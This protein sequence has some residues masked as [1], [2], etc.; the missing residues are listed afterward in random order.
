MSGEV[1]LEVAGPVAVLRFNRP[2]LG[3]AVTFEQASALATALE[4]LEHT[5]R[6]VVITGSGA[7]FNV[8]AAGR[9]GEN[10]RDGGSGAAERYRMQIPLMQRVVALL[11]EPRWISIA[12]INGGCAGAGLALALA[13]DL[14]YAATTARFNTAFLSA[15]LSGELGAI[16][17]AVRL[18]GA[19]RAHELFL[20]PEK[21]DAGSLAGIGLLN[22]VR[23][24][25]T[26][27]DS[28]VAIANRIA[29]YP[30]IATA[31]M[32][33]NFTRAQSASW[34]E[35]LPFELEGMVRCMDAKDRASADPAGRT[36]A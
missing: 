30:P 20:L 27:L 13:C 23:E 36:D 21:A 25:A 14:R 29:G 18:L 11:R 35:Y 6:V 9:P 17:L 28:V 31:G 8:G 2:D 33:A 16:W 5:V 15:G 24:P 26:M 3:N 12:A 10:G 34:E 4:T 32:K 7:T 1:L 22:G 19:G